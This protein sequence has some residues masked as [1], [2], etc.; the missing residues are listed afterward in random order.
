MRL[1]RFYIA[2]TFSEENIR[3]SEEKLKVGEL[4][5][6]NDE[7]IVHQ[8][9]NVFRLGKGDKVILFNGAGKDF[10]C[11]ITLVDK[12]GINFSVQEEK[13][14]QKIESEVHVSLACIRKER[15]EWA[16]EKL[17][18]LGVA[19]ITPIETERSEHTHLNI[20]RLKKIAIEASEQCGRG[21]IPEVEEVCSLKLVVSSLD[22]NTFVADFGGAPLSSYKLQTC[23]P[24]RQANNYKLL[25]GPEGGW[26]EGERELFK[27]KKVKTVS[28]GET[29]LRAETAAIVGSAILT[30][31]DSQKS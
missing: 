13:E 1:H 30:L 29:V 8:I 24:D 25:I 12:T 21:N 26:S 15:F 9:K 4:I 17:T 22:D 23:L 3:S 31:L 18:E 27:T 11:E 6:L 20:E 14:V 5:T 16:V 2:K 7:R 19:S 10:V 28:L